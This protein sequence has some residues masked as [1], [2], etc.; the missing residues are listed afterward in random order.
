MFIVEKK[1]FIEQLNKS[2]SICLDNIQ[3]LNGHFLESYYS[4]EFK[5][6]YGNSWRG[7]FDTS[8]LLY[9]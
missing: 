8:V 4:F 5:C 2:K 6:H 9:V 7:E 1:A 3:A